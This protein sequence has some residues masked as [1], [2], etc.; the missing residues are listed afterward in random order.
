MWGDLMDGG[1]NHTEGWRCHSEVGAC[2]DMV[3]V[4][5]TTMAAWWGLK[6]TEITRTII[7]TLGGSLVVVEVNCNIVQ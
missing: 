7:S 2:K 1:S 4:R 6:V 3:V 5:T